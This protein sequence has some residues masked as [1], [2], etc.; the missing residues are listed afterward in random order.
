MNSKIFVV[1]FVLA[2]SLPPVMCLQVVHA[3]SSNSPTL[4]W[5]YALP[6]YLFYPSGNA[7]PQNFSQPFR[8]PVFFNGTL[9]VISPSD[10]GPDSGIYAFNPTT[11]TQLWNKTGLDL[12]DPPVIENGIIYVT[13]KSL[14]VLAL[15]VY[16]GEVIWN[17]NLGGRGSSPV[18]TNGVI[19]ASMLNLY[20]LNATDG[21]ILWDSGIVNNQTYAGFSNAVIANGAIYLGSSDFNMYAFNASTGE[22]IWNY[23]TG[24]IIGCAPTVVYG[25]V[26]FGSVDHCVYA[27]DAVTGQKL[28]SYDTLGVVCSV[29]AVTN[30]VVYVG[31]YEGGF[32]AF[33]A[34]D[35]Q[36]LWSYDTGDVIS[37]SSIVVDGVVYTAS[38]AGHLYALDAVRGVQVWNYTV[39]GLI[40]YSSPA[41]I[42]GVLYVGTSGHLYAFRL[43]QTTS[44]TPS[45]TIPEFPLWPTIF[46][47]AIATGL[48]FALRKTVK[49][50]LFIKVNW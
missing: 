14:G 21:A 35:G 20:A 45:P 28:W 46:A 12:V 8:T 3:D 38:G 19:F 36:V 9:Y 27:L 37:M 25:V 48:V 10:G 18:V 22:K 33:N 17:H 11:G 23:T 30:G 31:S 24:G 26:Y 39:P 16:T 40:L 13:C 29:P 50:N 41:V 6:K 7:P 4:L 15:D 42:N 1:L 44:P 34:T 5:D 2:V 47:I 49:T 43:P 32:Y